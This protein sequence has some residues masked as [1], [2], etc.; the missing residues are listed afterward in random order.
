MSSIS[1]HF[2][3]ISCNYCHYCY[4]KEPFMLIGINIFSRAYFNLVYL[5]FVHFQA[6]MFSLGIILFELLVPF[7]TGMER[8]SLLTELR[9]SRIP[10]TLVATRPEMV[11]SLNQD[12][13][14]LGIFYAFSTK[15]YQ[16]QCEFLYCYFYQKHP[17]SCFL[18][19]IER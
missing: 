5:I 19:K 4:G 13:F 10:E 17:L 15:L 14:A 2:S 18:L 11:I 12:L 7:K 6:D 16:L 3:L 8:H 9:R 1:L